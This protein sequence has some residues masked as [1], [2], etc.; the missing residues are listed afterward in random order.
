MHEKVKK[1]SGR[2]VLLADLSSALVVSIRAVLATAL[3]TVA[4]FEMVGF[5]ENDVALLAVVE[6]FWIEM[7]RLT[8][9]THC[10]FSIRLS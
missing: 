10:T 8:E 3:A 5:G 7:L 6:V 4:A 1:K 2:K 9:D